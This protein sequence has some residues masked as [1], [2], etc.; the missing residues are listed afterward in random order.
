MSRDANARGVFA[1]AVAAL[2]LGACAHDWSPFEPTGATSSGGASSSGGSSSRGGASS[3][4]GQGGASSATSTG[5]GSSTDGSGGAATSTSTAASTASSA[6]SSTAA[7]TGS[8]GGGPLCGN[9]TIDAGE[10]C[11]DGNATPLDGCT[12]CVV[13]C[14]EPGAFKDPSSHHCYWLVAAGLP[15]AGAGPICRVDA[16]SDLAALSTLPELDA[17]GTAFPGKAWIG[18]HWDS[19]A[20]VW[21][22]NEPWIY[23]DDQATAMAPWLAM[24]GENHASRQ[25]VVML[26]ATTIDAESCSHVRPY[27]CERTP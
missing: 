26:S 6:S 5:G 21:S 25:C 11:D 22:F 8:G 1:A 23:G 7:S 15:W 3:V 24:R 9:G 16:H 12:N 27:V 13:D 4:G 20:W 2:A 19:S 14:A 18:G 17:V 10:E